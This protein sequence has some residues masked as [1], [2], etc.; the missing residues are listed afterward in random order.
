MK[1]S[2][3]T[4]TFNSEATL[5]I[6]IEAI[7]KLQFEDLEYIVIDGGSTDGTLEIIAHNRDIITSTISEKDDGIYDALNKG[8]AIATGEVI[9]FM[10]SDDLPASNAIFNRI[11][12]ELEDPNIDGVYGDL[13]YVDKT[14][15]EKIIR[16]WKSSP[17]TVDLIKKGWMPPHPT[18]FLRKGVYEKHGMFNT[19]YSIAAD[20]EFVLRIFTDPKLQFR[21]IPEVITKMRVGGASNR[22]LKNILQKSKEDLKAMRTNGIKNPWR[23][24]FHKNFS[25]I[26]QFFK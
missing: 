11:E 23:V 12:K 17:F 1:I 26:T 22:S 8:L 24:L 25:K 16:N 7:R 15:P 19:D 9:G 4:A 3:I 5:Q 2:L 6:C 14:N 20:Y 10:H 18:L 21:Y 13:H